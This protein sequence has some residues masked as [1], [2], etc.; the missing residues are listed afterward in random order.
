MALEQGAGQLRCCREMEI[1]EKNEVRTQELELSGQRLLDFEHHRSALPDFRCAIGDPRTRGAIF[2]IRE[3]TAQAGAA[4][5]IDAMAMQYESRGTRRCHRN[6][7]FIR[8]YLFEH[9][10]NHILAQ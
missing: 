9:S 8:F 5:N 1:S 3:P 4:F 10:D 7:A 2:L 6:S